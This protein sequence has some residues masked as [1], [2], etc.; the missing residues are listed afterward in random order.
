[1]RS[2]EQ[3]TQ[4]AAPPRGNRPVYLATMTWLVWLPLM[5]PMVVSLFAG[6][7]S[8]LR[9]ALSLLGLTAFITLYVWLAWTNARTIVGV[10][11]HDMATTAFELWLPILILLV[12]SFVLTEANGFAWG[13]LF[14]FTCAIASGRLPARQAA[15]LLLSVVLLT[16]V[17]GWRHHQPLADSLSAVLWIGFAGVTTITMVWSVRTSRE[18]REQRA[19]L[20]RYTAVTEERLRIARDLHDLLGHSLSLI[21]LKSEL[22]GRLVSIAPERARTEIGDI[23][24]VARTALQEVREALAGV[25]QPTLTGELYAARELLEAAGIVCEMETGHAPPE[26]LPVPLEAVLAWTVREGVTNVIRHSRAKACVIR[27]SCA[28]GQARVEIVNDGAAPAAASESGAGSQSGTGLRGL[29]ERV[30][31]L[32]GRFE[33]GLPAG[34]GYRLAIALPLDPPVRGADAPPET[35]GAPSPL[36]APSGVADQHGLPSDRSA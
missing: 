35:G 20:A 32:G 13:G 33:A 10:G 28:D 9:T 26:G 21:A 8:P 29:A 14:I 34:G 5:A 18:L 3:T 24:R 16:L 30:A 27:V 1:M 15:E 6:Q 2:A 7:V 25:R 17:F 31:A 19:E 12:L 4:P 36:P 11:P 23:E 22:A